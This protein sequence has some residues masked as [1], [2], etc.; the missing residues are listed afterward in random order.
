MD[1]TLS[2]DDE[3]FA[4]ASQ[5][6]HALGTSVNQ[7]VRDYLE[8]LAGRV[9]PPSDAQ[10]FARLSQLSCGDSQGWKFDWEELP[11]RVPRTTGARPR[12]AARS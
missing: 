2:I 8:C 5:R 12:S 11:G 7:L 10:E 4:K 9:D 6:A 1:L 3:L